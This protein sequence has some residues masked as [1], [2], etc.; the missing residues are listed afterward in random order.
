MQNNIQQ[1]VSTINT[2]STLIKKEINLFLVWSVL[3]LVTMLPL[4]YYFLGYFLKDS[5]GLIF[6]I[7][8]FLIP[9]LVSTFFLNLSGIFKS[10]G[11]QESSLIPASGKYP[12]EVIK[13]FKLYLSFLFLMGPIVVTILFPF[14]GFFSIMVSVPISIILLADVGVLG[15]IICNR[16]S[17]SM[18]PS[19]RIFSLFISL[20][21]MFPAIILF[22]GPIITL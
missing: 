4:W 10:G 14:G 13:I 5:L 19:Q 15:L 6:S 11:G 1:P 2:A 18:S 8:G 17:S 22:L 21:M 12:S 20:L 7:I 3:L 16:N 9:V